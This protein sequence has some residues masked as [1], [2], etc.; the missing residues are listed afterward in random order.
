MDQNQPTTDTKTSSGV[1]GLVVATALLAASFAGGN[2][3]GQRRATLSACTQFA[4]GIASN[5]GAPEG[6][7]TCVQEGNKTFIKMNFNGQSK[8]FNLNLTAA[9]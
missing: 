2:L 3:L 6:I 7:F 8:K 9:E 1:L 4:A 5:V